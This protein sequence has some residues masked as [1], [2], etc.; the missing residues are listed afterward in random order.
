MKKTEINIQD[1]PH[2]SN[3]E[4]RNPHKVIE[5]VFCT[6]NFPKWKKQ[7]ERW[8]VAA[9]K[10]QYKWEYHRLVQL[11]FG[12]EDL[13][14]LLEALWVI[15]KCGREYSQEVSSREQAI[16]AGIWSAEVKWLLEH[17]GYH[18][19]DF[20]PTV[21]DRDEEENPYLLVHRIF[22]RQKLNKLKKELH[23]WRNTALTNPWEY[24][25]MHRRKVISIHSTILQLIE[26]AFFIN[27]VYRLSQE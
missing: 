7:L 20:L 3:E 9:V 4:I 8:L 16:K 10:D 22:R 1:T 12:F 19:A 23:L 27:E 25:T 2:L 24:V 15:Y 13:E 21:L 14:R 18:D 11:V 5:E 26:G 17:G 6:T